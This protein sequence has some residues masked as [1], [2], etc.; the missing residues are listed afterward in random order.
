MLPTQQ[1]EE[2]QTAQL[3]VKKSQKRNETSPNAKTSPKFNCH[4]AHIGS[5]CQQDKRN[6]TGSTVLWLRVKK[7]KEQ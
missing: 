4:K 2:K 1:T 7:S 6:K 5:S 3:R